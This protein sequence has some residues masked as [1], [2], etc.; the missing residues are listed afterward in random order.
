[1]PANAAAWFMAK[2]KY[3]LENVYEY[4]LLPT[5]LSRYP[6][7]FAIKGSSVEFLETYDKEVSEFEKFLE[8]NR[9]KWNDL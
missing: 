4:Q 2:R 6:K 9:I 3:Y 1:M 8:S 5:L 7:K